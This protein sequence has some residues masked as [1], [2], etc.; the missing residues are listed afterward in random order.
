[1]A[2]QDAGPHF[3]SI[4]VIGSLAGSSSME[5]CHVFAKRDSKKRRADFQIAPLST[6]GLVQETLSHLDVAG[7]TDRRVTLHRFTK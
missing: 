1:M 5:H 2:A 6:S 4:N 7:H 3:T